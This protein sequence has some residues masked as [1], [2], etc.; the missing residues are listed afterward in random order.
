MFADLVESQC[1]SRVLLAGDSN[2]GV[3]PAD[4]SA[5]KGYET[6]Q[7]TVI[8][9]G[10]P[11]DTHG[12]VQLEHSAVEGGLLD[13][14]AVLVAIRGSREE[15]ANGNRDLSR[16]GSRGHAWG[17]ARQK[18]Y[19]K[20]ILISKQYYNRNSMTKFITKLL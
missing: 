15:A 4:G 8:G 11:D 17:K 9:T 19:Y 2:D 10:N 14:P 1:Q 13:G 6:E 3:A 16:C 18:Q 7:G 20:N 5:N 12:L